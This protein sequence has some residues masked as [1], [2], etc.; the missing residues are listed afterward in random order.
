MGDSVCFLLNTAENTPRFS[1]S[2]TQGGTQDDTTEKS[3][4][5]TLQKSS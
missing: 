4:Q 2:D 5:E 3:S 1:I